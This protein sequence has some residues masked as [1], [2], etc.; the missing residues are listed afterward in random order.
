MGSSEACSHWRAATTRL[1]GHHLICASATH[2]YWLFWLVCWLG[3]SEERKKIYIYLYNI[4]TFWGQRSLFILCGAFHPPHHH[5]RSWFNSEPFLRLSVITRTTFST[6]YK[7][8]LILLSTCL[9]QHSSFPRDGMVVQLETDRQTH[10]HRTGMKSSGLQLQ[11]SSSILD[12][13]RRRRMGLLLYIQYFNALFSSR[14]SLG[15]VE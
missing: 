15:N 7:L 2:L 12:G 3:E 13:V 11:Q 1:F 14:S 8:H 4:M 6:E 10:T 9:H 5:H